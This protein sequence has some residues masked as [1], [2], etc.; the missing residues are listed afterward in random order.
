MVAR[1][2]ESGIEMCEKRMFEMKW[3]G[4]LENAR[5]WGRFAKRGS[6]DEG[7][8][9]VM[10]VNY[11]GANIFDKSSARLKDC[12]NLPGALGGDIQIYEHDGG[13]QLAVF[14]RGAVSVEGKG[15]NYFKA[16]RAEDADLVVY[17]GCS[18]GGF[19]D[20]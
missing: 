4:D 3:T 5:D 13:A 2:S 19:N 16:Q 10:S 11:V 15:D 7:G 20:V 12:R 18:G 14:A 17:P 8:A 6:D 9:D 1:A